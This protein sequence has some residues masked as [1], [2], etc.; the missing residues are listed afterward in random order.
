MRARSRQETDKKRA[1]ARDAPV[2]SPLLVVLEDGADVA[3][4]PAMT[5]E[6][7]PPTPWH[8]AGMTR[9]EWVRSVVAEA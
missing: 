5:A 9:D 3:R 7:K 8:L 4:P 1:R 2:Q 6:G